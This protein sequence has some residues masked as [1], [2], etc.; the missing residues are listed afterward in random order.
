MID[1]HD[2]LLAELMRRR[3]QRLVTLEGTKS[4]TK[5][6]EHAGVARGYQRAIDLIRDHREARARHHFGDRDHLLDRDY[7]ESV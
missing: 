7:V 4:P 1:T 3:E 6:A 2:R 5:A